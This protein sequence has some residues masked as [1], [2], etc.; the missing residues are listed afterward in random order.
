MRAFRAGGRHVSFT[1]APIARRALDREGKNI[2]VRL[3]PPGAEK[4]YGVLL[5]FA[6]PLLDRSA[7]IEEI[8]AALFFA[9][10]I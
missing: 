2:T 6:E 4:M 3:N 7:P 5:R 10:T 8:R 1:Q 9:M